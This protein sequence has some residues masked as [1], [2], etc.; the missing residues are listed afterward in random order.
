M[1]GPDRISRGVRAALA[2]TLTC[3]AMTACATVPMTGPVIPGDGGGPSGGGG[4]YVR[5]LPAGPQ[6]GMSPEAL[7]RGFLRDMGSFEEDHGAARSYMV[8]ET[9]RTWSP[10]G[11]VQVVGGAESVALVPEASSDGLTTN[12]RM[13][14][15]LVATIDETGKYVPS[16]SSRLEDFVFT[17]VRE[18]GDPDG[19][20]RV[21]ELPDELIL[22]Q[23]DVERTHRSFNLYYYN[24]EGTALVP[25]PV[26][27]PVRPT[28][29]M[30]DRL[31]RRLVGGPTDWLAPAV[32]SALLQ[33]ATTEVDEEHAEIRVNGVP[34]TDEFEFLLG[35]QIAWTLRQVP[36]VEEFTLVVNGS[37]VAFPGA[38]GERAERPRP[39]SDYW[40]RVSPG[41]ATSGMRAY[42]TQEGQL[43]SA[44]ELAPD[45]PSDAE[46][47]PGPLGAGE[48]PLE[49]FAV[50]MQ[51][52]TVAGI[53]V[54]GG[55]VVTSFT[56]ADAGVQEVLSDGV[57]TGVSWD[58]DR[59][60]WVVEEVEEPAAEDGAEDG[61]TGEGADESPNGPEDPGSDPP[62]DGLTAQ[63]PPEPGATAL[64]MLRDGDE[65]V[66][67]DVS[68]LD[69]RSVVEFR[70]SRDGTRAAVVTEVD[71]ERALEVGR[72]VVDEDGRVSVGDFIMLAGDLADVTDIAWRSGDQLVALGSR[73]G[74]TSQAFLVSLDGGTP[75]ASAGAP[76]AGMTTVSGAP[77]QPLIA[78][79]E[80]GNVWLS[81]DRVNWENVV[82]GASPVYP[83]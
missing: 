21:S 28:D 38:D 60:L 71:G 35:A 52:S 18:N 40:A 55:E 23:L 2:A 47:V 22:S 59:N 13:S 64:W 43:W 17:L 51:E 73:E 63:A 34:E 11:S 78:G 12:V 53:T 50:S 3:A 76:V 4:A 68:E 26:Y 72:V 81:N 25:D 58:V 24:R 44:S 39:G 79:G 36:G 56:S 70:I 67:V 83:G 20:W 42:Y 69:D 6:P 75:P 48:V 16:D 30:A 82:E 5:L 27:L 74:G 33:G 8:E 80:D 57:F 9:A 31:L 1:I 46:R 41:A 66:G 77:G 61:G 7:V 45:A 19:E 15:T 54:G 29:E 10:S 14:T 62:A 65:V 37:E 49:R 32:N